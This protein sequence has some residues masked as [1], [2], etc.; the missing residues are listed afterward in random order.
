MLGYRNEHRTNRRTSQNASKG[1][2]SSCSFVNS[3][4]RRARCSDRPWGCRTSSQVSAL[5]RMFETGHTVSL[6]S[7]S[8]LVRYL[9]MNNRPTFKEPEIDGFAQ[10]ENANS[11]KSLPPSDW[12]K[13]WRSGSGTGRRGHS[14]ALSA[15]RRWLRPRTTYANARTELSGMPGKER[16]RI[17]KPQWRSVSSRC[18]IGSA[19]SL[20]L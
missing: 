4:S 10:G 20:A 8:T 11:I 1:W 13:V 16:A 9:V 3:C 15:E 14:I 7:S 17:R 12:D 18:F 6:Q 19:L 2:T 5:R